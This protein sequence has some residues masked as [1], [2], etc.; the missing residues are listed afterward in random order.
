MKDNQQKHKQKA[1]QARLKAQVNRDK[2][3]RK[4]LQQRKKLAQRRKANRKQSE[5]RRSGTDDEH[6]VRNPTAH[7]TVPPQKTNE[8]NSARNSHST[9]PN[10]PKYSNT[11]GR[12]RLYGLRLHYRTTSETTGSM[13]TE[14]AATTTS[15]Q[16]T[17]TEQTNE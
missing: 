5:S 7:S 16:N 15:E 4:L 3:R 14:D 1:R 17:N 13:T 11:A 6:G 12:E 8:Q 9:V 10:S 2:A